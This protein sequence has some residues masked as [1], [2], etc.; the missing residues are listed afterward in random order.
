[1]MTA[2]SMLS[3]RPVL[4]FTVVLF[5]ILKQLIFLWDSHEASKMVKLQL[6][7]WT[8]S[9]YHLTSIKRIQMTK[10]GIS[11]T[12]DRIIPMKRSEVRFAAL[13]VSP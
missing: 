11:M 5:F 8:V 12:P 10:A 3:K 9:P 7:V 2:E 1:M 6:I 4:R 13:R